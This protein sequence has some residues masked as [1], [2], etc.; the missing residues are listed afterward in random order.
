M[1]AIFNLVSTK[2]NILKELKSILPTL[3]F[4]AELSDDG[5]I[6]IISAYNCSLKGLDDDIA[7]F[8]ECSTGGMA[9]L[10]LIFDK[11]NKTSFVL[12]LINQFNLSQRYFRC[13]I[14]EDNYLILDNNFAIYN[15]KEFNNQVLE[16]LS[17]AVNLKE[18]PVFQQLT[19]ITR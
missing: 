16:F 1:D 13:Y 4:K 14:G 6:L 7:I 3:D 18:N 11:I 9:Y 5:Q 2:N 8:L 12:E 15:E 17:R 19:M 10:E